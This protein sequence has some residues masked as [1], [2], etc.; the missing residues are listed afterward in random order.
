MCAGRARGAHIR[1]GGGARHSQGLRVL[2]VRGPG[3]APLVSPVTRLLAFQVCTKHCLLMGHMQLSLVRSLLAA[4]AALRGQ[5]SAKYAKALF[6]N[7][8]SLFC[9]LVRVGY[10]SQGNS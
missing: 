5:E 3:A 9:R 10:S 4:L 6:E 7:R 1:T 8:V 2:P